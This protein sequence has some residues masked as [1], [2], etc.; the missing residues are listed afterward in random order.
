[1]G[2]R[3]VLAQ[4][5]NIVQ[6]NAYWSIGAGIVPL[7]VFDIVVITGVQLK[8]L[9]ELSA[10]YGAPFREDVAKKAVMSLMVGVGGVGVGGVLGI[11]LLKLVPV[12]GAFVGVASVPIL[13]G[14]LA[15]AVGRTFI[16][17][18][19][20]GGTLL[21]FDPRAMHEYFRREYA[22]A[23]DVVVALHKDGGSPG[24]GRAG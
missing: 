11:S 5:E 17:H 20:S 7:P 4:A 10:L 21:D 24:R 19:E 23:R 6:R 12:V 13:S 3:G 16:M 14:M 15:Y 22:G 8:M 18:F 9:R 1:M 2:P